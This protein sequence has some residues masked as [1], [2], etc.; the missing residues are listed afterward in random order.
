MC[1]QGVS[2][3]SNANLTVASIA[4][5]TLKVYGRTCERICV[6]VCACIGV[7]VGIGVCIVCL[8]VCVCV[9]TVCVRVRLCLCVVKMEHVRKYKENE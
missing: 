2:H 3:A 4:R 9:C 6:W 5:H 1:P 8:H 7:C